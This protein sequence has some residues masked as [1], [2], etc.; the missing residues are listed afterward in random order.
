MKNLPIGRQDFSELILD[1]RIYVDKTKQIYQLFEQKYYFLSRPRR[2]GKSLLLNTIKEIFLGNKELFKGLWIYDKIDWE[3]YPLIKIS[4]SNIEYKTIGLAAAISNELDRIALSYNLKF[5]T[6]GAQSKFRSLIEMLSVKKRVVILI[7]EYD[8]PIIDYM[9][10]IE[11]AEENREI[12]KDFYSVIK[13]A[14]QYIRF[15]FITGVS[16]FSKVSIFSDLNNLEDI[17]LDKRFTTML[18]WTQEEV[19]HYF[20]DYIQKVQDVYAGYYPDIKPVIK[21]WYNGY[22][23]DGKNFVYNPVSLMNLFAK[24][25]FNNYW[26]TT[27]T[28]TFLTKKIRH[29]H[30][31]AFDIE[32]RTINVSLLDKYDLQNMSL[33]PLLFQTGYLTIKSF[34]IFRNTF[35]LD[36][37]NKEVA[38]SFTTHILAELTLGKLDKTDMLLVDIVK[39]FDDQDMKKFIDHINTLFKSI[40]YT[41]IEEKEKYFHSLFYMVMKL[42]GYKIEAEIL[43]IDGRIDAVVKTTKTIYIIEFK[44]NQDAEKAIQQIRDK[45]YADKYQFDTRQKMLFGINFNTQ[46]KTVDDYKLM[47]WK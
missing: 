36:Y 45:K 25:T 31:T 5:T 8:K 33:I 35:V 27:G 34:D 20:P 18:G 29:E 23:W 22:S 1:K 15:F 2:F 43:T 40:P 41:I 17:T 39:S 3:T 47:E 6:I 37:P 28:P 14:D 38:D 7:D 44:I 4:F 42:T 30:Y 24:E 13:D 12:L 9:T 46:S 26:F 19:E 16:K 11:K 32:K 21:E 10:N